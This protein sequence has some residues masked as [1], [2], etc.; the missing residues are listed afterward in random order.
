MSGAPVVRFAPSPTGSLHV[1]NARAALF[2]FLFAR[3]NGGRFMLRMDDTDDERSTP[4]FAAGIEQDLAWLGLAHDLFARQSERL[5]AYEA[6]A[7]KLKADGRLYPAYETAAE[8]DRK[9]KRQMARGLPPVYD[10]AALDLTDE[11]RAKLEA[12]GRKPHWRFRLDRVHTAFEDLVQ[13]HVEVDG[14]SLSDPVLIREDGRF[15]YT[16]PSVVDDIDFAVT[17]V[18]RGS[19]HITNTGVQIQ[20]IRALGAEPPVYAHYSLLNGPEGKPLSKR[21]DAA[22]FSLRALREAGFEPMALNALLARLGTPDPVEP[23]LSLDELAARFDISRLGRADIRFDPADLAKVNTACLHLMSYGEAK[24]RLAALGC[25]LGEAFWEAVKPNLVL[26]SDAA[27]WARVVE[28]PV[29]P[30]IENPDFAAAAAAVLPPEPWDEGTWGLWTNAVKEAT[31]AKG[32]A[33]F[34]PLRLALTGLT[35]G[36][37]LKNLLPLIGRDRA[38][39]RLGGLTR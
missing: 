22:R 15:L 31:G 17:H 3:K 29:E 37:E 33:L 14:A 23:C 30:V 26:F 27:D 1:G 18:I 11:D 34:M 38:E 12:E 13:G 24:P 25:D 7:E 2:N 8:L 6:A 32:K 5:P 16:L 39:A 36:P 35:H 20:I 28:G 19:D 10:R 9:R 21:D 4:E